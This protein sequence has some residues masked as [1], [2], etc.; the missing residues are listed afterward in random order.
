MY[1]ILLFVVNA[2]LTFVRMCDILYTLTAFP[3]LLA[4]FETS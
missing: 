1:D 3:C 4:P 2:T